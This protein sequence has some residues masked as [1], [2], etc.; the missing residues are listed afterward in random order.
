MP[1]HLEVELGDSV[2]IG[3]TTV[4]IER[5]SGSR[6]RLSIDSDYRVSVE[7][8]T[9]TP[10]IQRPGTQPPVDRQVKRPV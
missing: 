5:K 7:K 2:R 3:S 4:K 1:L 8:D 9:A 10:R 6:V